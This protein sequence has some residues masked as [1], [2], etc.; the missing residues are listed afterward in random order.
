M[1]NTQ[2]SYD[3]E[4]RLSFFSLRNKLIL[5]FLV[6]SLVPLISVGWLSY[7]QAQ[8]ALKT[9]VVN[10]LMAVRDIKAK[11]IMK[12]FQE[13]L[14]DIKVLSQNPF[15]IAALQAFEEVVHP[16]SSI[17]ESDAM[18]HFRSLYLD[19]PDLINA[20]DGSAYSA[21]HTQNHPIFQNYRE[22]YGYSDI[23]L[24]EIHTGTIIYSV[25]KENDFGTSLLNGPYSD[26]NIGQVFQKTIEATHRDF[27]K[28]EDFAYYEPSKEAALFM[29]S[30]IF[31]DAK[32]VGILIFQ[33]STTQIDAI[34]QE[35]TGLGETGE[36]LLVSSE[37]FLLRSNSR[38]S[39]ENTLF[40]Q[41]IDNKAS[42]AAARGETGVTEII[43]SLGKIILFAYTPLTI[44][45][46]HW[47]LNAQINKAEAFAGI[48]KI[49]QGILIVMIIG[50]SLVVIIALFFSNS[51][52]KSIR[53]MTDIARQ[54]A[55]GHLNL[56]VKIKSRDEIGLMGIAL[57]KMITNLR[58]VIEDIV[59]L[60]QEL[61]AGNLNVTPKS[62]YRGDFIQIKHALETALPNQ[63]QVIQDI[64][65]VSQ[66][67]AKGNLRV[68]PQVQYQG[69]FILVKEALENALLNLRQVIEDIVQVAQGLATG[70]QMTAQANYQGDFSQIKE[71]LEQASL[72]LSNAMTNTRTQDWLKT[73]QTQLNEQMSGEQELVQLAKNII[74]FIAKY[75][76]MPVGL[77]YLC[78]GK[79][80]KE[81]REDES[82]KDQ[83]TCEN[84]RLKL[85]GSYAY[86]HRQSIRNEFKIGE[87]LVGQAALEKK[88][89]QMTKVPADYYLQIHSGLGKS[90][91]QM[92]IV[93]P[94][95]YENVIKGVVEFASFKTITD[96][97]L[98]FLH[99]IMPSIGIAINTA[100]SRTQMQALL[101]TSQR[102][103][104]ILQTQS[105][106]LQ[107]QQAE[108]EVVNKEL[109]DQREVLQ[110]KQVELQQHNEELQSQSEELQTQQE[111]LRQANDE[112]EE[113]TKALEQQK[114]EVQAK[115]V[116]FEKAQKALETKAE[117]LE[118]ASQY[119]SE[120]LANM[121]HELRTPLN[122]LL[123]LAN[124]LA[125]NKD[126]NLN[127][128]QIEYARTIHNAGSELLNLIN[129]IL[130]LSKVEAGKMEVNLEE[131]PLTYLVD[132]LKRKFN[133]IAEEKKVAFR[134]TMADVLPPI[135]YT[136]GKRLEQILNNLL[137]NAFK[138]TQQGHVQLDIQ[139]SAFPLGKELLPLTEKR[140]DD[141]VTKTIEISVSDTGIGIPEEKQKVIFEA[142]QQ[143]D[144]TTSRRF[145]GTGLG[146]SISRQLARLLGG[147][148]RLQSEVGKGSM[149]TL[150]LPEKHKV[151][152]SQPEKRAAIALKDQ[153][154]SVI[155]ADNVDK[156]ADIK[157]IGDDRDGLQ[158]KDKSMLIIEDDRKFA[159][160]LL[161]LARDNHFKGIIAEDGQTGLQFAQTYQPN[162]IILDISLPQIDGWTVMERLKDDSQTRHIP[163]HFMSATE[164]SGDA[165]KMGAI[166]YLHKPV[167]LTELGEAFQ[168][169][170]QFISRQEKQVLLVVDLEDRQQQILELIK[171]D[172]IQITVAATKEVALKSLAETIF[173]CMIL[174]VD[175]EQ[176]SGIQFVEQLSQKPELCQIPLIIYAERDLT[177][178]EEGQLLQGEDSL[179]VKSVRSR[180]RLLDETMLFVHQS[181]A[182]L[183][184]AKRD[185]LQMVHDKAAI[186][187]HKKVLVVDDDA[188]NTFA[189]ATVLEDHEMEII[190][191]KNG[192]QALQRLEE[193]GNDDIAIILMDIMMPEMDGYEAMREI[194]KQSRHHQLPIIALT[195]KAMKG[196]KAKCIEAGANDYLSKPVDMEKLIS[197]MRV[198]LYR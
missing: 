7:T 4:S 160:I 187:K 141:Q 127:D 196:D 90:V 185:M 11:Q 98:V 140:E 18:A 146:L 114:V 134:V 23:F 95:L 25:L 15:T 88:S 35:P 89:I 104:E 131:L 101:Q 36:T 188:R 198:W 34:M 70:Q 85:I 170:E 190:C 152:T 149:F 30:P 102:Q 8:Q 106:E 164:P 171:H 39:A 26:T 145:G 13:R 42:Q 81:G 166:G 167:N 179:T 172:N 49:R 27:T 12:Y 138:F 184:P 2:P 73:G 181:E 84:A 148:L 19:K 180:E 10:K 115:N 116:A 48:Q 72:N 6:V 80:E 56:T 54:L 52:T 135:L 62:E 119:K 144:G 197:L 118:L 151:S 168:K 57:Q 94:F 169:I 107:S 158:T 93:Q 130:D 33:L 22:A 143:V 3:F 43:D 75:L 123:I 137:S 20:N 154:E 78:E 74:T 45:D 133:H 191:A 183:P 77:F 76:E 186:L 63:R 195:A 40:K 60:S 142:F 162:A 32:L 174:D 111:E 153:T 87:G 157:K 91:P 122:S 176:Q 82:D 37:D 126:N 29:A 159:Q 105:E 156:Q 16:E 59:R 5:L 175:I 24:V 58:K 189:L 117:E 64:I 47:S 46:V 193:E 165:K 129:E 96:I 136:D 124:L 28:L 38:F 139:F 71:A 9:E 113:R 31:D 147:E 68:L 194:R 120:F 41:K 92:V 50:I 110:N 61:A 125:G 155:M 173:D 55:E 21:V 121:S 69:D 65:Q 128:K 97:Q 161:E 14:G 178:T 51:L 150:Y 67:L 83:N 1:I 132:T 17:K 103:T 112:L 182:K 79:Q 44:S 108:L 177:P 53:G 163:V 86:S 192:K 99:Q 109:E 66:G 100:E